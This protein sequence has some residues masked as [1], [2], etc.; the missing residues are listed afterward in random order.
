MEVDI[1][2]SLRLKEFIDP[3]KIIVAES[4][5]KNYSDLKLLKKGGIQNFLI[6]ESLMKEQDLNFATKRILGLVN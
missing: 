5:L 6:G 3:N 4:G 1:N 2:N